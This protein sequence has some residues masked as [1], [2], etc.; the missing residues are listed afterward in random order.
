MAANERSDALA[1][2]VWTV[3]QF[4][5]MAERVAEVQASGWAT[6]AQAAAGES[7]ARAQCGA[8]LAELA[9]ARF[10]YQQ[11]LAALK[12]AARQGFRALPQVTVAAPRDAEAAAAS[13]SACASGCEA[14]VAQSTDPD[15]V[16]ATA[17]DHRDAAHF[18][19][20]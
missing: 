1:E 9:C 4:V 5:E 13:A 11:G 16:P 12:A 6:V 3:S 7:L 17:D 14:A 20:G 18:P 15:H 19:I 2:L 10:E 8:A